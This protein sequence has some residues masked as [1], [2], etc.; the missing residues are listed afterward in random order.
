MAGGVA[1]GAAEA[2]LTAGPEVTPA[3]RGGSALAAVA[4][5][6]PGRAVMAP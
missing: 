6:K 3:A 4:P 5:G 2:A 1:G